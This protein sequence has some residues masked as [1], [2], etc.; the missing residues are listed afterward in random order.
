MLHHKIKF[1]YS[2]S[3]KPCRTI[4]TLSYYIPVAFWVCS[5]PSR[6]WESQI[7]LMGHTFKKAI[8]QLHTHIESLWE[9]KFATGNRKK[10]IVP[11][12][13]WGITSA[14]KCWG[15]PSF[16]LLHP[17]RVRKMMV[18]FINKI[19]VEKACEIHTYIFVYTYVYTHKHTHM[20]MHMCVY[21]TYIH[22]C[23]CIFVCIHIYVHI[24]VYTYIHKYIFV[25]V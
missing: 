13:V 25:C 15:R 12:T 23:T 3:H 24:Y 11:T 4:G 22:I 18:D 19:Q 1:T 5:G 2:M 6:R 17:L 16:S 21:S 20:Y 8:C 10:G 14:G 7:I 9:N